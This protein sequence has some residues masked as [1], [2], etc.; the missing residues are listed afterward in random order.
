MLPI[1]PSV[2]VGRGYLDRWVRAAAY[3][4]LSAWLVVLCPWVLLAEMP[5]VELRWEGSVP[6]SKEERDV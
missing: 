2:R 5:P 6:F 3:R 4:W 1:S